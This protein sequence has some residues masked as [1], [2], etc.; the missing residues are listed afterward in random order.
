MAIYDA[1]ESGNGQLARV[2]SIV[3]SVVAG[4][5]LYAVNRLGRRGAENV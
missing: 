5:V 4:V 1:V 2:L 3:I